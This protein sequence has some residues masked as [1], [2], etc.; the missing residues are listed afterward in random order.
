MTPRIRE[1]LNWFGSENP[2][3]LNHL[4]QILNHGPL[5]GSGKLVA[6][7]AY[8]AIPTLNDWFTEFAQGTSKESP[9]AQNPDAYDPTYQMGL[10]AE[11]GCSAYIASK[12]MIEVCGR[13]YAGDLPLILKAD[14]ADLSWVQDALQ[15]GCVGIA[16][17][18]QVLQEEAFAVSSLI[19]E[20]KK[21]GL[22]VWLSLEE[23]AA[24]SEQNLKDSV[25]ELQKKVHAAAQLGA[26]VIQITLH[27]NQAATHKIIKSLLQEAFS[28][29]RLLVV[30]LN[31]NSQTEGTP[32]ESS[33]WDPQLWKNI[34]QGHA[35]GGVAQTNVLQ[36]ARP[37]ALERLNRMM[38]IFVGKD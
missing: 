33:E 4:A 35:F 5:K 30:S 36:I 19:S 10:A 28:G 16:L 8:Q 3:V 2:G 20:C 15:L 34:A 26:H 7:E 1:I 12:G 22:V 11:S 24:D 9:L 23:S 14:S 13:D 25:F 17:N 37:Q 32:T 27:K 38:K 6:L 21:M 29:K 31:E 18:Q